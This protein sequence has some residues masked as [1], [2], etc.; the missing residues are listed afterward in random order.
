MIDVLL[1]ALMLFL[2]A[3]ICYHGYALFTITYGQKPCAYYQN[4][5]VADTPKRC[6]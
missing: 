4:D 6:L 2:V 5:S 3:V 1:A